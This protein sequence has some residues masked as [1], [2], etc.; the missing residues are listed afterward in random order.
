MTHEMQRKPRFCRNRKALMWKHRNLEKS[1]SI[2]TSQG[3]RRL[4]EH[5]DTLKQPKGIDSDKRL[6]KGYFPFCTIIN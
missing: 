6:R 3:L 5:R 2:I 4:Q 1:N